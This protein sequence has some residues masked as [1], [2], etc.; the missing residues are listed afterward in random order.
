MLPSIDTSKFTLVPSYN[1]PVN[2]QQQY[3]SQ[4]SPQRGIIC[5]NR[6][7]AAVLNAISPRIGKKTQRKVELIQQLQMPG[8]PYLQMLPRNKSNYD[9]QSKD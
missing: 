7:P 2:M 9:P 6:Q 8:Y 5:L 4:I 1:D 3:S